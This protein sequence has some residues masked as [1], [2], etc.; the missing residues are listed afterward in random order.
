MTSAIITNA[1]KISAQ[2]TK[3]TELDGEIE[4]LSSEIS[5]QA[6]R[7]D[8]I[9]SGSGSS[10][11]INIQ[12][13]VNGINSSTSSIAINADKVNING[14]SFSTVTDLAEQFDKITTGIV[15]AQNI[16][17]LGLTVYTALVY[18]GYL[19]GFNDIT[20]DGQQYH[21]VTATPN[22]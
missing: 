5:Q 7:I 2:V 6:D 21:V 17:V 22:T 15:A 18:S 14:T 1:Q 8:L 3:T 16:H 19:L 10:A 20:I 13:I 11:S 4:T 9:V 12:N